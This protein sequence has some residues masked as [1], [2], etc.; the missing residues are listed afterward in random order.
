MLAAIVFSVVVSALP[1]VHN[2]LLPLVYL[3]THIHEF[4]H[5]I[6]AV[7]TGGDVAKIRVFANGSGVT[8]IAGGSLLLTSAAG[9]V[10]SAIIGAGI[11]YWG[12][13]P[14]G[15]TWTLRI[16]AALLA[17]SM[18]IWVRGDSVGI[19]SGFGWIAALGGASFLLK[20][21]AS[22]FA[23]QFVGVQQ[24]LNS[25]TSIYTL[26][27]L[28]AV[29]EA[30]SD[31]KIMEGVTHIPALIWALGWTAFSGFVMLL[32]LRAAW[33]RNPSKSAPRAVVR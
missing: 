7:A 21:N 14:T 2:L 15:A 6:V 32:T 3:N 10:G 22:L 23:A 4:C 13:T 18:M 8:D 20:G 19:V 5:A 24:C 17:F 25:L 30:H 27:Q 12:R 9:Y 11:I 28:S 31:A 33:G 16:A 29:T 1:V 26:L